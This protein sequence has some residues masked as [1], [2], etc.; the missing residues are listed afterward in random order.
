MG[1]VNMKG[2]EKFNNLISLVSYF[3]DN[4]TCKQFLKE[5]RWGDD[6]VCPF[7]GRHHCYSRKDGSFRCPECLNNFSVTKGTIFENTKIALVKW[8]SAMYLISSHKKGL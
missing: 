1:T 8:F 7:C 6:V 2:L 5:Q 3:K 4:A